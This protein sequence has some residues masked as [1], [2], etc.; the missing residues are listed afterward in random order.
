MND[1]KSACPL[2]SILLVCYNNYELI[3]EAIDSILFQTYSNIE[4]IIS[5]DGSAVFNADEIACYIE[6]KKRDNISRIVINEN[7]KN[8]GTV[9]HLEKL[10]AISKGEFI[11]ALAAD[12]AFYDEFAVETLAK[13]FERL[14]SEAL[15]I[16][17]ETIIYDR[18]LKN[19]LHSW[20]SPIE[21]FILARADAKEQ[22]DTLAYRCIVN[23]PSTCVRRKIY[24]VV[25]MRLDKY[26][27]LED[28]PFFSRVTRIGIPIYFVDRPTV[29]YR[30]GGVSEVGKK[31]FSTSHAE[32][33][34]DKVTFIDFEVLPYRE[35]LKR[36]SVMSAIRV[37]DEALDRL[38][39][40]PRSM[41]PKGIRRQLALKK[42]ENYSYRYSA[43][44]ISGALCL[45]SSLF[46]LVGL[47]Y[48]DTDFYYFQTIGFFFIV[49]GLLCFVA[50]GFVVFMKITIKSLVYFRWRRL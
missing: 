20:V 29:K 48:F 28:R 11:H 47:N 14:G 10:R 35:T 31:V 45:F 44:K 6:G 17:S 4:L 23:T 33:L 39:E 9:R 26:T 37:R 18:N 38:L 34:K 5:D 50:T 3:F 15:I 25:D 27:L 40:L 32:F 8:I 12:D 36:E 21:K 19:S 42:L 7:D 1:N 16:T 43:K 13:E 49:L 41:V 24:D 46:L 22:F 2:Y 30:S